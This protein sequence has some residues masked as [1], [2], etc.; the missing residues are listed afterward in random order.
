MRRSVFDPAAAL[1]AAVLAALGGGA[2]VFGEIDDAPGLI[3]IGLVLVLGAANWNLRT[4]R[5]G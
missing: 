5:S 2:V 4:R 3:L 1:S